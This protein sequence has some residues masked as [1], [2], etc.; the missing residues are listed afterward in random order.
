MYVYVYKLN[1]IFTY[2][3]II[4]AHIGLYTRPEYNTYVRYK[5]IIYLCI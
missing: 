3:P 1:S 4:S 2:V 5:G